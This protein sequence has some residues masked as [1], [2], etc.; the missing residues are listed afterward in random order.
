MRFKNPY[1]D[2][3][4]LSNKNKKKVLGGLLGLLV[5]LSALGTWQ[6]VSV[7]YR[8]HTEIDTFRTEVQEIAAL[9]PAYQQIKAEQAA[10]EDKLRSNRVLLS[11]QIQNSAARLGVSLRGLNERKEKLETL[12]LWQFNAM[13]M[14]TELSQD[15]L[16]A[17]LEHLEDSDKNGLVKVTRLHIKSRFDTDLLDTRM[18]VSTWQ[19]AEQEQYP[20][21]F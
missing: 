15:R 3:Q 16:S 6:A 8:L 19:L 2:F 14:A 10:E 20:L 5:C 21:A 17:F 18:I 9:L 11:K 1:A 7:L 12:S 4:E 13:L